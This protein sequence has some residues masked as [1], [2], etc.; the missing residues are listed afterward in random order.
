MKKYDFEFNENNLDRYNQGHKNWEGKKLEEGSPM[1][2][3]SCG[4]KPCPLGHGYKP[5]KIFNL[6]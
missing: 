3:S 2:L 5:L 6:T 4:V 1:F